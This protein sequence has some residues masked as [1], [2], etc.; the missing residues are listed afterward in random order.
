MA[1]FVPQVARW[2]GS[3]G[4]DSVVPDIQETAEGRR[5]HGAM[6][7]R[8]QLGGCQDEQGVGE[9]AGAEQAHPGQVASEWVR[10]L[11]QGMAQRDLANPWAILFPDDPGHDA[12]GDQAGNHGPE[13]QG[14]K[15]GQPHPTMAASPAKHQNDAQGT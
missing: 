13:H 9:V 3:G 12:G 5:S 7:R 14:S 6:D 11:R 15:E 4:V 1:D 8:E 10:H 2:I